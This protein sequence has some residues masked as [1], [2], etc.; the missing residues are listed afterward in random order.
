MVELSGV[1]EASEIRRIE[2]LAGRNL[3]KGKLALAAVFVDRLERDRQEF[4]YL[5]TSKKLIVQFF[6]EPVHELLLKIHLSFF[7]W[8]H[9][10]S[11]VYHLKDY[12]RSRWRD[13]DD[14]QFLG[15][16]YRKAECI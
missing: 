11:G 8:I 16:S 15:V 10:A 7:E 13:K 2:P 12:G 5:F 1:Y 6:V 3:N 9:G 4:S 14:R